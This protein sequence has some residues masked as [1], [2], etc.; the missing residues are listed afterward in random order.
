M[1]RHVCLYISVIFN[2]CLN[3]GQIQGDGALIFQKYFR[4]SF[5]ILFNGLF[6][7]EIVKICLFND[8]K[9]ITKHRKK[10]IFICTIICI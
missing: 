3:W 9:S 1:K 5:L 6:R 4:V 7:T 8:T 10:V 2:Q